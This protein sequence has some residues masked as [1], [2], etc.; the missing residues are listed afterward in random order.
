[1]GRGLHPRLAAPGL[2]EAALAEY[3]AARLLAILIGFPELA[4]RFF[5]QLRSAEGIGWPDFVNDELEFVDEEQA[6]REVLRR[7]IRDL[8]EDLPYRLE[9]YREWSHLWPATPSRRFGT[10]GRSRSPRSCSPPTWPGMLGAYAV[11]LFST[12]GSVRLAARSLGRAGRLPRP[13]G[14]RR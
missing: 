2:L 8:G 7:T 3:R 10:V 9:P 11:A 4:E 1:V 13:C 12:G 5:Q 14:R 6:A